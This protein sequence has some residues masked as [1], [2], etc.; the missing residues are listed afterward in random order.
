M[1]R[2]FQL[3]VA[4]LVLIF[5]WFIRRHLYR[6]LL[7][8]EIH[9][10]ARIGWSIVVVNRCVLKANAQIWSY[11]FIRW[12]DRL[13]MGE[14]AII[15]RRNQ[16]WGYLSRGDE[17]SSHF[18]HRPDRQSVLSMGE[19]SSITHFHFVD[20]SDQVTIGAFSTVAGIGSQI[21]THSLDLMENRQ[22]CLPIQIGEYC[23]VGTDVV[24]LP[25]SVLPNRSVLGAKALLNTVFQTP[26]VLYG[27]VPA[28]EI[29]S[30]DSQRGYFVREQGFVV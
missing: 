29:A 27:G 7:G 12:L 6:W 16:I 13:E 15:G 26:S 23:F 11:N 9:P 20:C 2:K 4:A 24:I 28:R 17:A 14:G 30:I 8:Y 25:G 3:L 10:T 22:D 21:L 19:H 18:R 1:R 5:P